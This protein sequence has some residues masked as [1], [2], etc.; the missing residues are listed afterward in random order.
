MDFHCLYLIPNCC[1]AFWYEQHSM[2]AIFQFL[3]VSC[4]ISLRKSV[5]SV[6]FIVSHV[7]FMDLRAWWWLLLLHVTQHD[8]LLRHHFYPDTWKEAASQKPGSMP[9]ESPVPAKANDKLQWR[10][11]PRVFWIPEKRPSF[12]IF[13]IRSMPKLS[14][15]GNILSLRRE[16]ES[17]LDRIARRQNDRA[18][19]VGYLGGSLSPWLS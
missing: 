16:L 6:P 15:S 3:P 13:T 4:W 9:Q 7:R 19:L 1:F 2:T 18:F 8:S 5:F 17:S 12:S 11:P 10:V 14:F